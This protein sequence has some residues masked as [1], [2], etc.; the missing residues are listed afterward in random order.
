MTQRSDKNKLLNKK[1]TKVLNHL[2]QSFIL[3]KKGFQVENNKF[4]YA[5]SKKIFSFV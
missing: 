2:K 3:L 5:N 4:S 1:M